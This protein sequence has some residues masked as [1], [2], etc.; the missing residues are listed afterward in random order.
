MVATSWIS[1]VQWQPINRWTTALDFGK[2]QNALQNS[3]GAII[4]RQLTSDFNKQYSMLSTVFSAVACDCLTD[5]TDCFSGAVSTPLN[6]CKMDPASTSSCSG[7]LVT[8]ET[9][10]STVPIT[11]EVE[12]VSSASFVGTTASGSTLRKRSSETTD[13]NV[14]TNMYKNGTSGQ[15]I[16]NGYTYSFSEASTSNVTVCT[17]IDSSIPQD[18]TSFPLYGVSAVYVSRFSD[19]F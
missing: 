19:S 17:P 16:G 18:G 9:F 12:L 13:Y 7:V 15:I 11:A 2:V 14:V 1:P 4:V 10:N 8:P 3:I 6:S 5:R